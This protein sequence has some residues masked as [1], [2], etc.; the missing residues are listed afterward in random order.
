MINDLWGCF[1]DKV[2]FFLKEIQYNKI[3]NRDEAGVVECELDCMDDMEV[4][5][6][7]NKVQ[8]TITRLIRFKPESIFSMKISFSA[9]LT[10]H[11]EMVNKYNWDSINLLEEFKDNG[12]Y[13]LDDLMNRISLQIAQ[14][15]SAAGQMPLIISPAVVR[16]P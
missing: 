16:Q 6:I 4:Q 13:V 3:E 14:I 11:S 15:T 10:I 2:E 7:D 5:I 12:G 1:T 9:L 8:L